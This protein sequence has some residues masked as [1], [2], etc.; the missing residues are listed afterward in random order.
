MLQLPARLWPWKNKKPP[1]ATL[2]VDLLVGRIV[3]VNEES[4]FVLIDSGSL[5]GPV[6]G[7]ILK[8]RAAAATPVALRVTQIR[9]P[10]FFVA[11]IIKGM[12]RK[13]DAVYQ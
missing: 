13:G 6:V 2:K 10:P 9:K 4:S 11:D 1:R 3:M 5:P 8:T 12:P 7:A